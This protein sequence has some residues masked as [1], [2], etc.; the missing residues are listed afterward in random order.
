MDRRVWAIHNP[1]LVRYGKAAELNRAK[2]RIAL[3]LT[4]S[5]LVFTTEYLDAI[6]R[7]A[8]L[9]PRQQLGRPGQDLNLPP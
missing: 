6:V 1:V 8:C 2:A 9:V 4:M 7:E 5:D 3:A